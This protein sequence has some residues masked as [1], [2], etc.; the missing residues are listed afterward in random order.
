MTLQE[1]KEIL[2]TNGWQFRTQQDHTGVDWYA[3]K[4]LLSAT[5]CT[6]NESQ[7]SVILTPWETGKLRTVNFS[8]AGQVGGDY[9][10]SI[11]VYSVPMDDAIA[12]MPRAS[13]IL[14]CAWNAAAAA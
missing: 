8:V 5:N 3:Y 12:A 6:S 4:P 14:L 13:E 7:P 1:L 2:G 11:R 10:V 9:W